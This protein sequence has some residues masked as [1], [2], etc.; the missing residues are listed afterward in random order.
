MQIK[1]G[2]DRVV[3]LFPY[4]GIAVKLPIIRFWLA[5]RLLYRNIKSG[6]WEHLKKDWQRPIEERSGFKGLLFRGLAA[7]WGEFRFYW[8]TRNPFLQPTYLSLGFVNIQR[9]D[10]P[11]NLQNVDLWY[12]LHELTN[13]D[14]FDDP[15]HSLKI[16]AIS[17]LTTE[18]CGCS[19]MGVAGVKESSLSTARES[20]RFSIRLTAGK[21]KRRSSKRNVSRR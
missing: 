3:V 13:G 7:N 8:Q 18:R 2:Q 11:C 5:V 16:L 1:K 21:N 19:T 12:Q 15:H 14:V 17:A 20:S 9:Y 4:L 6:K 10:E